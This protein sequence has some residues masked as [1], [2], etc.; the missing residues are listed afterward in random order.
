M[1]KSLLFIPDISGFTE[2][3]QTTEK[4]H[5]QHVISELLEV[6]IKATSQDYQ[7][8]E[9]EGDALFFFNEGDIPSLEK[10]L[11]QVE[12]LFTAFYS[13]LEL[14]K[15]NRVCP[16]MACS[17]AVHLRL[18]VIAHS[19][20]LQFINVQNK[21][22][23]FGNTV[24]EAHRLLKNSIVGN[25]Y[26]LL[27]KELANDLHLKDQ[28]TSRLFNFTAGVNEYDGKQLHYLYSNIYQDELKLKPYSYAKEVVLNKKP[29]LL[30]S[31]HFPIAA[32]ELLEY[33]TN[34]TYRHY[35]VKGVDKFEF[36]SHEVTRVGTDHV[37][38]INGKHLNFTAVTKAGKTNELVYGE[39][40]TNPPIVDEFYQ[41]FIITP[42]GDHSSKLETEMYLKVKS[43][44]KKIFL[45]LIGKRLIEKN[46]QSSLNDLLLFIE[47][48]GIQSVPET[49]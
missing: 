38:V 23:P 13:H 41:F 5:S 45:A 1:N 37:C 24:I 46:I 31:G 33:I 40:A 17:S 2:F 47:G 48:Q 32:H 39:L 44:F 30:L 43:P 42:L 35:W 36:N 4:E 29:S 12:N 7:L 15:K 25:N 19:G 21:R 10:L 11:A 22:K 3:V 27:T 20:E 8:A 18:K 34:Y 26:V 28:Y 14:L 6:L 9:I 49:G 16:C